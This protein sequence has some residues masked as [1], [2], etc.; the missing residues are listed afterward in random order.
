SGESILVSWKPPEQPNGVVVQYTVYVREI[1]DEGK[2][3]EPKSQKVPPFQMSYEASS[4]KK[5]ERYEFWVTDVNRHRRRTAVKTRFSVSQQQG[6]RK[7]RFVRRCVHGHVQGR[8]EAAL[9][10]SRCPRP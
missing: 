7:D 2:E 10:R 4:L 5:K 9:S 1:V 6:P 8:R 3:A